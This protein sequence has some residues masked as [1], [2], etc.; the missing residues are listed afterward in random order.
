[1]ISTLKLMTRNNA[2]VCPKACWGD[3]LV[4]LLQLQPKTKNPP[5]CNQPENPCEHAENIG[6]STKTEPQVYNLQ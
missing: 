5:E 3:F 2:K 6:N 4:Q 1:M